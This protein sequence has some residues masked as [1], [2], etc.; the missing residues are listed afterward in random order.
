MLSS[1]HKL[2]SDHARPLHS[3]Q[4]GP[5]AARIAGVSRLLFH[6]VPVDMGHGGVW[7]NVLGPCLQMQKFWSANAKVMV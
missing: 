7:L 1:K 4:C 2:P 3:S 6:P 5:V